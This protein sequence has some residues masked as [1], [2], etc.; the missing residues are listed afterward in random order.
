MGKFD[1]RDN[2]PPPA[3]SQGQRVN[4]PRRSSGIW[5]RLSIPVSKVMADLEC[6]LKEHQNRTFK[7]SNTA[8]DGI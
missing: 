2:T 7:G 1:D 5:T 3:K 4:I 6:S 8:K